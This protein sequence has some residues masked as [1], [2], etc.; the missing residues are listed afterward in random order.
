MVRGQGSTW[1]FNLKFSY[2]SLLKKLTSVSFS[3]IEGTA[4]LSGISA[5]RLADIRRPHSDNDLP[6]SER[7]HS[8][9]SRLMIRLVV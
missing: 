3:V 8:S 5:A 2:K 6:S 1:G 7:I 9:W 4:C